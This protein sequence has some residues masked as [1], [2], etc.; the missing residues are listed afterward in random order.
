MLA[1]VGRPVPEIEQAMTEAADHEATRLYA[2]VRWQN[3]AFNVA[4]MLG[5]AGTVHGMIIAFYRTAHMP[6]G[7]NK[8]ERLATGIYAALVCTLRRADRGHPRRHPGPLL[9]RPHPEAVPAA[10]RRARR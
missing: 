1:K 5:L 8:M 6:L 10:G 9:R 7:A 3:L 2:N 4:P